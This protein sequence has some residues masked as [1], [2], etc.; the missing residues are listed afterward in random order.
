MAQLVKNNSTIPILNETWTVT[1]YDH[2]PLAFESKQDV[3]KYLN[4]EFSEAHGYMEYERVPNGVEHTVYYN[5]EHDDE[6]KV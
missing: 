1:F 6:N 4:G 5:I 3:E 2:L